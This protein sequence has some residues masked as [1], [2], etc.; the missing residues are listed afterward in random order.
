MINTTEKYLSGHSAGWELGPETTVLMLMVKKCYI[1]V[2]LD[3]DVRGV[4]HIVVWG[5]A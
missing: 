3:E 4:G 1:E 5:K 2:I